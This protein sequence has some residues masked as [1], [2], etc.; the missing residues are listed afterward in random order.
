MVSL[1]VSCTRFWALVAVLALGEEK[2]FIDGRQK[3]ARRVPTDPLT[4]NS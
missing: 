3:L 1:S 4:K 2:V